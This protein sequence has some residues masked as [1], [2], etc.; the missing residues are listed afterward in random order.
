VADA[1]RDVAARVGQGHHGAFAHR[2]PPRRP[3]RFVLGKERVARVR[4]AVVD[5]HQ[6]AGPN[7]V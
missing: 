7:Y 3:H 1:E 2:V 5:D 6:R 4:F